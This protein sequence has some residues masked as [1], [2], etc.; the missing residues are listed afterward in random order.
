MTISRL[1]TDNHYR[2]TNKR[3][4]LLF[5]VVFFF[6]LI[7]PGIYSLNSDKFVVVIDAGHGGHDPG[8]RGQLAQEKN[9][10]LAIAL[11]IQKLII[12]NQ[13]DTKVI[14]TRSTDVFIP[15]YERAGIANKNNADLFIS[16]HVD[17][18]KNHSI[19]GTSSFVM[20]LHKTDE[21]F[22]VA[23]RENSVI[24]I[25]DNHTTQ[26]ENFDPNSAESYII[27]SLIQ[28]KYLE[29]SLSLATKIQNQFRNS[30]SRVDRGV[31]Q[32]GFLVLWKTTMP[33]VL[34]E[35]G[36]LTNP[37]EEK[38]LMSEAGQEFIAES[39]YK[40]FV[41]YK[42][43]I[44]SKTIINHMVDKPKSDTFVEIKKPGSQ[45]I[46]EVKRDSIKQET[47]NISKTLPLPEEKKINSNLV[48]Y[49]VQIASSPKKLGTD[50]K[51]FKGIK[52]VEENY[53]DGSYKYTI[54]NET[55]YDKINIL[56]KTT[57]RTIPDAFVI[58]IKN[59]QKIPLKEARK[60]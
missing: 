52:N 12:N 25:E 56:L 42:N 1:F 14:L 35:T 32:A 15:L 43:E 49:K 17:G 9:I 22:E 46:A 44:Q 3:I 5:L 47:S 20:G 11:K 39:V 4:K 54:G 18:I 36:F 26:Y 55:N 16:I 13:P 21:N 53:Y 31:K 29:Q 24:S 6:I 8:T 38:Y 45:K 57:R 58:A 28:N 7:I 19:T 2:T 10:T 40:A 27:F 60:Q 51:L 48:C 50:P 33:S 41:D 37:D 23:K 30:Y 59:G 34:V